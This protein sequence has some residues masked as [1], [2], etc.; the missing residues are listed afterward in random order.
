MTLPSGSTP[1][2]DGAVEV[3][4]GMG[5]VHGSSRDNRNGPTITHPPAALPPLQPLPNLRIVSD[6]TALKS[7]RQGLPARGLGLD[8][9]AARVAQAPTLSAPFPPDP[10]L[11]PLTPGPRH[12]LRRRP[13]PTRHPPAESRYVFNLN[14]ASC[15]L[16]MTSSVPLK[17][18]ITL[19]LSAET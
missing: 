17:S 7:S 5:V 10:A 13:F 9:R 11:A 3:S 8:R 16:P 18:G 6:A 1:T 14:K 2:E 12:G 19:L 4:K 15:R